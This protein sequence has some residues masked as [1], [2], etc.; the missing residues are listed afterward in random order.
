[1]SADVVFGISGIA[2][3]NDVRVRVAKVELR[4][5]HCPHIDFFLYLKI[6]ARRRTA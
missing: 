6:S 5:Q 4:I 2:V 1:V 3:Y